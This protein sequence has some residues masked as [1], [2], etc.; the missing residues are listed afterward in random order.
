[1][2]I[3]GRFRTLLTVCSLLFCELTAFAAEI[4]PDSR[5]YSTSVS[6]T[7]EK[8]LY[9]TD[10]QTVTQGDGRQIIKTYNRS[11][12]EDPAYIPRDSFELDGWRYELAEIIQS[13]THSA[14]SRPH[15]ATVG[16]ETDSN[17]LNEIIAQLYSPLE[18]A[19][20]AGFLTLIHC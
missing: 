9:P 6:P 16:I 8:V 2:Y 3:L 20:Y 4:P 19:T 10:V 5:Q 15:P 12:G 1:M 7:S 14:D 13:K 17:G 11:E 18:H